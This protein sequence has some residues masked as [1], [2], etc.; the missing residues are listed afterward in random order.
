M[1]ITWTYYILANGLK[2]EEKTKKMTFFWKGSGD[3]VGKGIS[4]SQRYVIR[5]TILS[6]EGTSC[7][8]AGRQ[9]GMALS[10]MDSQSWTSICKAITLGGNGILL[11]ASN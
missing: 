2:D 11:V 9:L 1:Q 5:D 10:Q 6:L 8:S 4:G 7:Y 3:V